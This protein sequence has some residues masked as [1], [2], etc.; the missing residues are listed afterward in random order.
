MTAVSSERP[1]CESGDSKRDHGEMFTRAYKKVPCGEIGSAKCLLPKEAIALYARHSSLSLG[2]SPSPPTRSNG[3][4]GEHVRTDDPGGD[5]CAIPRAD[6]RCSLLIVHS[7][8]LF[9]PATRTN[10]P[11]P[12]PAWNVGEDRSHRAD[13]IFPLMTHCP[14]EQSTPLAR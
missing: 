13:P 10:F 6:F 8:L 1:S 3:G 11:P 9:F 2:I 7:S 12:I 4:N 14:R 5:S